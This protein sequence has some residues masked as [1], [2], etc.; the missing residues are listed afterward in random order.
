MK[1]IKLNLAEE[2]YDRLDKIRRKEAPDQRNK[3]FCR[4]LLESMLTVFEEDYKKK[5]KKNV[6]KRPKARKR[7]K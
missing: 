3:T 4:D 6:R 1:Q 7:S 5:E 2:I